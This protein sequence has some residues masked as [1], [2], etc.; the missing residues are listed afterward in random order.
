MSNSG[1][2]GTTKLLWLADAPHFID[3][4]QIGSFYDAIVRPVGNRGTTKHIISNET[5]K[6]VSGGIAA[7]ASVGAAEAAGILA[8]ILLLVKPELKVE[9]EAG[10]E[11]SWVKADTREFELHPIETPQRQLVQ[12]AMHYFTEFP[13]RLFL[14]TDV[15]SPQWRTPEVISEVPRALVFLDLPAGTKLIPT[16][17]EFEDGVVVPLYVEL[18]AKDASAPRQPRYPEEEKAGQSLQDARKSYWQW[19]A[20]HVSATQAMLAIEDAASKHGRIR[21]IDYRLPIGADGDT[22]H[23]HI[24]ANEAYDTG[25]F[26]YNLVKRASKHGVRLVGTLRSEPDMSVLAFYDK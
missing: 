22:L 1:Q 8:P 3:A 5:L 23:L 15:A 9:G 17:A 10:V 18:D 24:Q 13:S 16:A 26:A 21:W 19:F 7:S 12:L 20:K 11:A 2:S 6:Q 14:V 4:R 25:V